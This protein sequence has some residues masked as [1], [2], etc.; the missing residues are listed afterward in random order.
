MLIDVSYGGGCEDH[1]FQVIGS[2]MISKS[3]P[4]VRPIQLVHNANGDKCKMNVTKTLEIDISEFTYKK[5]KGSEIYL[6]LG[7]WNQ[8]IAY[9]YEK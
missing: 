8:Q 1:Q 9:T 6:T 7:G 5:E 2:P 4:P 3:L